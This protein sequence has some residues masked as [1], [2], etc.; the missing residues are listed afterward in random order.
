MSYQTS[1]NRCKSYR[2]NYCMFSANILCLTIMSTYHVRSKCSSRRRVCTVREMGVVPGRSAGERSRS[3]IWSKSRARRGSPKFLGP[4]SRDNAC[5]VRRARIQCQRSG[6]LVQV[7]LRIR[8]AGDPKVSHLL[9][10]FS[11]IFSCTVQSQ[12]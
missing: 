2:I 7:A 6:R 11:L 12:S 8:H 10:H 3:G 4:G 9:A 5:T 1:C